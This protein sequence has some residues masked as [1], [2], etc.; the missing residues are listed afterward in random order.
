MATEHEQRETFYMNDMS[1]YEQSI[2]VSLLE[3]FINNM[4][5]SDKFIFCKEIDEANKLI[6]K[7]KLKTQKT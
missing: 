2:A 1:R 4:V 3:L 7:Y 5:E 6:T